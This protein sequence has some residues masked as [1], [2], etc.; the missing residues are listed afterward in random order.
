VTDIARRPPTVE[1]IRDCQEA[2]HQI[3][4]PLVAHLITL[5]SLSSPRFM[6]SPDGS[7]ERL[8]P[9][10]PEGVQELIA[11]A[12]RLLAAQREQIAEKFGL[13]LSYP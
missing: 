7:F 12:Q 6:V 9:D 11:E 8:E 1:E 10:Y 2:I 13:S 5:M 3:T 4:R